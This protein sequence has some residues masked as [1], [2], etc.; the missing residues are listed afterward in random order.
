MLH[1]ARQPWSWPIFD[2]GQKLPLCTSYDFTH[3]YHALTFKLPEPGMKHYLDAV[4]M[5]FL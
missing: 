1:K 3:T 2:V 4:R 5:R